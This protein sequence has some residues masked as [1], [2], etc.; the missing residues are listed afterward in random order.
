MS[1]RKRFDARPAAEW[2]TGSAFLKRLYARVLEPIRQCRAAQRG[3]CR[4][5]AYAVRSAKTQGVRAAG[6]SCAPAAGGPRKPPGLARERAAKARATG[7]QDHPQNATTCD[8]AEGACSAS[9][10]RFL[11]CREAGVTDARLIP[12]RGLFR[13]SPGARSDAV[14]WLQVK[15]YPVFTGKTPSFLNCPFCLSSQAANQFAYPP[16]S[17]VNRCSFLT[18]IAA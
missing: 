6:E 15:I 7:A 4:R 5:S 14:T 2:L 18:F 11:G 13:A 10:W 9:D 8:P 17:G 16:A 3:D 12:K 1:N